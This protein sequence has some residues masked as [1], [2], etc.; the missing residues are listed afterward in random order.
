MIMPSTYVVYF[1]Y[2]SDICHD[3]HVNDFSLSLGR[4]SSRFVHGSR[5]AP[6]LR[7]GTGPLRPPAAARAHIPA[8]LPD[9]SLSYGHVKAK[10]EIVPLR[11]G[12]LGR[13]RAVGRPA[14]RRRAAAW[15]PQTGLPTGRAAG[16]LLRPGRCARD[17]VARSAAPHRAGPSV[18]PPPDGAPW[19]GVRRRAG[20][21]AGL[22][23]PGR[24]ARDCAALPGC[25]ATKYKWTVDELI[26][27]IDL[28]KSTDFMTFC[29][30][31]FKL[32]MMSL[33]MIDI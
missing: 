18:G 4:L 9:L 26:A 19:R 14:S 29:E 15:R 16:S 28:I 24:C 32:V 33:H 20:R 30:R 12:A 5:P 13:P 8:T 17:G 21:L 11:G 7:I 6:T 25:R 22:L 10:K 23:R 27:T 2:I 1:K 3:S 31:S